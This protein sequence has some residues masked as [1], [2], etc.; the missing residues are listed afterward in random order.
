MS[1]IAYLAQLHERIANAPFQPADYTIFGRR[2]RK[3]VFSSLKEL[4][5]ISGD[6]G[7][8]S[9]PSLKTQ[10]IPPMRSFVGERA[11]GLLQKLVYTP[12]ILASSH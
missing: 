8:A 4:N 12:N 6:A 2:E 1:A 3:E 9:E 5:F 7:I 11:L 10:Y